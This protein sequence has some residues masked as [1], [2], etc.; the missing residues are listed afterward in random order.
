MTIL[1]EAE[2]ENV[3]HPYSHHATRLGGAGDAPK[4]TPF[5]TVLLFPAGNFG[6]SAKEV[7]SDM[8][9][10][11]GS[12]SFFSSSTYTSTHQ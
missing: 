11:N 7:D 9:A 8:V 2:G 5:L 1:K 6:F 4:Q 10:M 12:T 3:P